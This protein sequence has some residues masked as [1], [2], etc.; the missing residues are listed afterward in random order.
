[1]FYAK[2]ITNLFVEPTTALRLFARQ[3]IAEDFKSRDIYY[4]YF[5]C[6]FNSKKQGRKNPDK[7]RESS[8]RRM[9]EELCIFNLREDINKL[10]AAMSIILSV[11]D[12]DNNLE[13]EIDRLQI[14]KKT[15]WDESEDH[16]K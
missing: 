8:I 13:Y 4:R 14:F 5:C 9:E 6:C 15:I 11:L 10:K 1:M 16:Q 3:Q 7:F 12:S 2:V